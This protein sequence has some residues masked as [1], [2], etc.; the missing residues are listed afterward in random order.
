MPADHAAALLK[1][2]KFSTPLVRN[3]D[4]LSCGILHPYLD[5]LVRLRELEA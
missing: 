4:N 3:H 5:V 2:L 1:K